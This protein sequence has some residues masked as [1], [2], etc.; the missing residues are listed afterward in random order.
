[1]MTSL[2]LLQ[3]SLVNAELTHGPKFLENNQHS[4]SIVVKLWCMVKVMH[5]KSSHRKS[6]SLPRLTPPGN[7]STIFLSLMC[8]GIINLEVG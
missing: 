1:M 7:L 3:N 8:V 2:P 4:T 5:G 6:H